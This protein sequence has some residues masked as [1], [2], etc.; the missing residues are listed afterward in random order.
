MASLTS[1]QF[2]FSLK[3]LIPEGQRRFIPKKRGGGQTTPSRTFGG[4]RSKL[5]QPPS[6]EFFELDRKLLPN[7]PNIKINIALAFLKAA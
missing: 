3:I 2:G 1:L 7:P 5:G 4:V 6:R